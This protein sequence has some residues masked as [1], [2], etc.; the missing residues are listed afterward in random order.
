MDAKLSSM[1]SAFEASGECLS[2]KMAFYINFST[3]MSYGQLSSLTGMT[4]EKLYDSNI[5][6]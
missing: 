4:T 3:G 5:V 6:W 2:Y 1:K